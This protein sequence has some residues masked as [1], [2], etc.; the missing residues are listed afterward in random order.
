MNRS[1]KLDHDV[2]S[3]KAQAWDNDAL[4]ERVDAVLILH[5]RRKTQRSATNAVSLLTRCFC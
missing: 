1:V 4:T 5:V 2:L 3:E